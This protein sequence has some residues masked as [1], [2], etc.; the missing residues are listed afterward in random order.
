MDKKKKQKQII[1]LIS[2]IIVLFIINY[3]FIDKALEDF[4]LDYEPVIIERI[5]DGDT[6]VVNG[7]SVRLLGINCPEKGEIY[8]SEAKD[9]LEESVFNKPAKLEFGK[10]KYDRYK[11][12]LAYVFVENKNINLNLVEEGLANFY[13]PSGKDVYYQDFKK[14]WEKCVEN[15]KNLCENS[16]DKCA[17]CIILEE[18][19]YKNQEIIFYNKCNFNCDLTGW[20]IKDE[21]R[22]NFVFDEFV[23]EENKNVKIIVAEGINDNENLF[24]KNENYVWTSSGDT[25]FLRDSEN[26]LIL[27]ES[28]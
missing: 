24:W 23:L 3:S 14:A 8:Y 22:K 26:R 20:K 12:I 6:L 5:I 15:N 4:L 2:L 25:L 13:F 7:T 16:K 18:F 27:W 19:N 10:D 21:G 11:R 9:F 17:D 28:Y 1:L